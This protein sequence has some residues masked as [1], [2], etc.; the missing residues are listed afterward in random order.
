VIRYGQLYGPDTYY[1]TERPDPP[2]I[3]VDEAA[4]HTV[5]LLDARTGIVEI[6]E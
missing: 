3:Q 5:P 2:R 1:E 6:V 4:R